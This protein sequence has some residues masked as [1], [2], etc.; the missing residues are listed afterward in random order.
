[1]FA[2]CRNACPT[3][4]S[5][6][7]HT[8]PQPIA[9]ALPPSFTKPITIYVGP[10]PLKGQVR[11]AKIHMV[12]DFGEEGFSVEETQRP[13]TDQKVTQY[14]MNYE[15]SPKGAIFQPV[16]KLPHHRENASSEN[17]QP[18]GSA[19]APCP[20]VVGFKV[21]SVVSQFSG[22][23]LEVLETSAVPMTYSSSPPHGSAEE[24]L[25]RYSI[26]GILREVSGASSHSL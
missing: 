11:I 7:E 20:S 9:V 19:K 6:P 3:P 4:E 2:C 26:L 13:S 10:N 25:P 21:P 12:S 18:I 5:S 24:P 22:N 1:M 15:G 16:A 14:V 23:S 8:P 17:S